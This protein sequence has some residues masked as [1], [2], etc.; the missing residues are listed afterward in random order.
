METVKMDVILEDD[1]VITEF[2][3]VVD[4]ARVA[5]RVLGFKKFSWNFYSQKAGEKTSSSCAKIDTS[6][7]PG[8]PDCDY[9]IF[10]GN[11][12]PSYASLDV[13]KYLP[14]YRFRGA[15]IILLSEA[16]SRYIS[17]NHDLADGSTTHWE[18]RLLLEEQQGIFGIGKE[19]STTKSNTVTSAGMSA[20]ADT[21][22][23][24]IRE[25]ISG[26]KFKILT[27]IFLNETIRQP[28]TLQSEVGAN[29]CRKNAKLDQIIKV[30]QENIEHPLPITALCKTVDRSHRHIER[31]FRAHLGSSP[32]AYYREL[33]LN[34]AH[35]LLLNSELSVEEIAI[36]C[37]FK[38]G[39][40]ANYKLIF[41]K[42]SAKHRS[43][44]VALLAEKIGVSPVWQP[45]IRSS[46][47]LFVSSF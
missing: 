1:F 33:R 2:A 43:R 16:A 23:M 18:N 44:R 24:L 7:I 38:S 11:S 40:S 17:A 12:D 37:G 32:S 6:Q 8:T 30:M 10:L 28:Q 41:G 42:T 15:K 36:A 4:L 5:N 20:T 9:A 34:R 29:G 27:R 35:Y 21:M 14:R 26:A 39:L 46:I 19:L 22:L 25:H 47:P 45:L 3:C 31:L 13:S